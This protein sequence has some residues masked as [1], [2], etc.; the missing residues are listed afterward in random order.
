MKQINTFSLKRISLVFLSFCFFSIVFSRPTQAAVLWTVNKTADTNDGTCDKFD[1][2]LREAIAVSGSGDT[3]RFSS[4]L[5]DAVITLNSTLVLDNNLIIDGSG[6]LSMIKIDGDDSDLVFSIVSGVSASFIKLTIQYGYDISGGGIHH[7]GSSLHL[8]DCTLRGNRAILGGGAIYNESTLV[9]EGSSLIIN[10]TSNGYGGAIYNTVDGVVT[11][12]DS[13]LSQNTSYEDGGAIYNNEGSVTVTGGTSFSTNS[14]TNTGNGDGGAI[15]NNG[16]TLSINDS[17]LSSNTAANGGGAIR[18]EGG[19]L[20]LTNNTFS[21]NTATDSSGG[22]VINQTASAAI[23]GNTF[24]G[25]TAGLYGGGI[26]NFGSSTVISNS[27]FY[28]NTA[29]NGGGFYN[30][31]LS[32]LQNCTFSGNTAT[33]SS[34]GGGVDNT[35]NSL[36]NLYN[37]IIANSI[38]GYDCYSYGAIVDS[39]NLIEDNPTTNACGTP[40]STADPMLDSLGDYGGPTMTFYLLSGSP[41]IDAGDDA[42]CTAK[43]QRGYPRPIGTHCDLGA[44]EVGYLIFLPLIL[45]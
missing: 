38:T 13:S 40:V 39:N 34:A 15:T 25:N 7:A 11:I 23:S 3:I 20:T 24:K 30:G 17:V 26:A 29:V 9:I 37:N 4:S 18:S 33:N 31:T 44:V 21:N 10:E 2:S 32:T 22:A 35:S 8:E 12:S 42:T 27:T 45:R 5:S 6:L 19:S 36:L 43:D 41:A 1:C 16:G 28:N 14:A